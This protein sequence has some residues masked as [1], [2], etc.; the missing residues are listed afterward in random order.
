MTL[1][2]F[3]ITRGSCARQPPV[4]KLEDLNGEAIDGIYYEE[5]L[6]PVKK[7]LPKLFSKLIK[8]FK[9]KVVERQRSILSAG[10]DIQQSLI[11]GFLL[12]NWFIFK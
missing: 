3:R 7:T 6:C 10:V 9:L 4:Y 12:P 1:E 8:F 5:E 2:I 11:P